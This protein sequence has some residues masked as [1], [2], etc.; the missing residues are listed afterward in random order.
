MRIIA[1]A[2]IA[3]T[4]IVTPLQAQSVTFSHI[5]PSSVRYE[6]GAL[7]WTQDSNAPIVYIRTSPIDPVD[8]QHWW[9][10]DFE[11]TQGSEYVARLQKFLLG[12]DAYI[13]ECKE[14]AWY[15]DDAEC[16][17]YGPYTFGYRTYF[18]LL[19]N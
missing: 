10:I 19:Q 13:V 3:L 9:P 11:S 15:D 2:I 14:I 8:G 12:Y 4:L 17:E 16:K 1:L 7:R 18:P 6:N 5:P